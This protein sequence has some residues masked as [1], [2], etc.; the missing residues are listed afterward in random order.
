MHIFI[1]NSVRICRSSEGQN[2][3][4][5]PPRTLHD[6]LTK[7]FRTSNERHANSPLPSLGV[8][9]TLYTVPAAAVMPCCC[10]LQW[11]RLPPP[12]L[13]CPLCC[14]RYS[15]DGWGRPR[16]CQSLG[17]GVRSY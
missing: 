12:H 4:N 2:L 9:S 17:N 13:C 6:L 16:L 8:G 7:L 5:K 15:A 3:A 10:R 11:C 1:G 14:R